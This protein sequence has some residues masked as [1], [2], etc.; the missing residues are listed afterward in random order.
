MTKMRGKIYKL[1]INNINIFI[2]YTTY[3]II[4]II[5]IIIAKYICNARSQELCERIMHY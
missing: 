1:C 2:L 4:I 5:I 3:Y